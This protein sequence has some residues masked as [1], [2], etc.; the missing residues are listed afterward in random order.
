MK[1][2]EIIIKKMLNKINSLN[3]ELKNLILQNK[4][5]RENDKKFK[6]ILSLLSKEELITE[7]SR[8]TG[9]YDREIKEEKAYILIENEMIELSE[10][11]R[12]ILIKA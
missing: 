8:R 7:L 3:I 6:M 12:L 11:D 2:K 5:L 10:H 9:V 1:E 4:E